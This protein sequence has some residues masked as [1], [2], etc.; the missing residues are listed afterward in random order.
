MKT[1][2][3]LYSATLTSAFLISFLI[4]ILS[5]ASTVT[6]KN[7]TINETGNTTN[8]M[9]QAYKNEN[10]NNAVESSS[11]LITEVQPSN[12]LESMST[13][14]E[15]MSGGTEVTIYN[16]DLALV[17]EKRG[18]DLKN[19][20][21][22]FEY[23]DVASQID[24]TSVLVEDPTN[25]ET[26]VLEQ[27]YE[28]NL[29]SNSNLLNKYLDKEI[30]VT[31]R[32][33]KNYTGRLLSHDEKG[34][35]LKISN[36]S[37]IALETSKVEFPDTSELLTKPTLVWQIYSPNSGKRDLIIS[38]LTGGISWRADY[39][40]KTS[41]DYT[42][43]D[44]RSW[45][46][47]DNKAG[48][49]F[50]NAK[51]KLVAGEIH[52]VSD[53]AS[54]LYRKSEEVSSA[55]PEAFSETPLFE[56]HLY[57]L[58]K[59]T[60]LINNQAKQISLF[61]ADSV[62]LQ[63][64]LVFDSWKGDKVQVVLNMENSEAQGLGK[65]IP[66]GIVR[67]YQPDSEGQLQF[68]GEDQIDHTPIGEKIKVTV[69]NTFDIIGKRTQTS[70]EQVSNNIERTSYRIELNNSKSEAQDVKVVEHLYGDWEII[71]N[72][73]TYEKV[74]A[75]TIEFR[76]SVP[77][78]ETKTVSYTIENRITPPVVI[79]DSATTGNLTTENATDESLTP[80]NVTTENST[81]E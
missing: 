42:K 18:I 62:P 4:I 58:E 8:D 57:T 13:G 77:A 80:E 61:S 36:G 51:L 11:D 24:P 71:Q 35:V 65:P 56:Y 27:Q 15:I 66:K 21:N 55:S 37:V 1:N 3:K 72:S 26:T 33:G 81:I 2:E 20:T 12:T 23:T 49:T 59:P 9:D 28:Y 67:V 68:L 25:N 16:E 45:V 34:V 17:K 53:T 19:G 22:S 50:E 64:E 10:K 30:T 39:I 52:R 41:V 63:K 75:F 70:Y 43:G 78:N 74:D 14:T 46:S 79:T 32:E 31:D 54:E 76:V 60:T 44:I 5:T 29:I 69:G 48:K 40:L 47:I 6:A 7:V 38:Y 73:D